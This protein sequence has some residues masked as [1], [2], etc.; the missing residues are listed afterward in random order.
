MENVR[1][2][3]VDTPDEVCKTL[4]RFIDNL[5]QVEG[6]V[7]QIL[8]EQINTDANNKAVDKYN[9]SI[10][11]KGF[12]NIKLLLMVFVM[13]IVMLFASNAIAYVASDINY[14]IASNP[15][16]LQ[17]YLRDT[18][19]AGTFAFT[20][21]SAPTAGSI[22]QGLVYFDS[23]VNLLKVSL[24]G[25]SFATIDTAGGVSLD[26]AYDFGSAGG[27]RT[28]LA[29]DGAV[30]LTNTDND[31]A[32]ILGITYSGNTTGDGLT[33]T[34]SNGSGDA[35]EIE[36][37]GSGSDIEGTANTWSIGA[38]GAFIGIV[39]TWT[40]DQ[41]WTGSTANVVFDATDD[42]LLVEDSAILSFGDVA[43]VTFSWNATN[44]LIEATTDNVGQI[45]IGTTNSMDFKIFNDAAD[46]T[47]LF[48]ISAEALILN[49]WDITI[50]DDDVL[51]FG[52]SKEFS[53][54][55]DED[56]SDT[57]HGSDVPPLRCQRD[58]GEPKVSLAAELFSRVRLQGNRGDSGRSARHG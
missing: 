55:Y 23:G 4:N 37:T 58:A 43:D 25:S 1:F 33:I 41:T 28:I 40:G 46:S 12:V 15:E 20:P 6:K 14:D 53:I 45:V 36:N 8:Q 52:D 27:G 16:T 34:M 49:G 29:T 57:E 9:K 2:T 32:S 56:C 5:N 38:D 24:D 51:N 21:Q 47:V 31:T 3:D 48:D 18:M 13:A 10:G 11:K 42:E 19:G 17:Q 26:G 50:N 54:E 39:G 7:L 44:L 30:Q 35:I 22:S